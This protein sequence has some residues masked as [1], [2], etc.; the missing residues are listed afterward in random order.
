MSEKKIVNPRQ[1]GF[2]TAALLTGGGLISVQNV[3][4]RLSHGDTW[5]TYVLPTVYAFLV[6]ALFG[7][8]SKLFPKKQLYEITFELFGKWFGGLL[9]VLL[10][11][12]L[13]FSLTRDMSLFNRFF[14]TTL[15]PRTPLEILTLLLVGVLVFY[16]RTSL[17]VVARVCDIVF[18]L[19]VLMM[20]AAPVVLLNEIRFSYL[21]PVMTTSLW[22]FAAG[23]TI[24][25]GWYGDIF[26]MGAFIHMIYSH[27]ELKAGLRR[28]VLLA[29]MVLT[30]SLLTEV[31]VFGPFLPG[32]FIYPSYN[33]VQQIHITD[34]LDRVDIVMLMVWFPIACCKLC[35][36]Y[37]AL[38]IGINTFMRKSNQHVLNKPIGALLLI[39]SL[40]AFRSTT[41]VF[42]FG[43]FSSTAIVLATQPLLIVLL[44]LR[45]RMRMR[46]KRQEAAPPTRDVPP[47]NQGNSGEIQ[48]SLWKRLSAR[49]PYPTWL[50]A[51]NVIVVGQAVVA[52]A[53]FTFGRQYAW[54]GNVCGLLFVAGVVLLLFTTFAEVK[55]ARPG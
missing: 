50:R 44:F 24:A 47:G 12:H 21:Q 41:E 29:T 11:A 30:L 34:F 39:V 7:Y 26:A 20:L 2:L 55:T 3:L 48:G 37:I 54:V 6:I 8:L 28:G 27:Q 53:G 43:N 19:F 4:I 46:H 16:G 32:N 18:P 9:N 13:W 22:D 1:I 45:A 49:H 40:A 14:S 17:E 31:M 15:L 10:L 42:D 36:I 25:S 23:G 35:T 51:G 33:L 52:C 5:F 38:L